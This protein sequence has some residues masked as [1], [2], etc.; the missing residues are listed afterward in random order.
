[1]FCLCLH[2]VCDWKIFVVL[3]SYFCL[4]MAT[5]RAKQ[6]NIDIA[7]FIASD[8]VQRYRRSPDNLI[9]Y[10]HRFYRQTRWPYSPSIHW[11]ITVTLQ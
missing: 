5:E 8:C 1:M 2:H 9:P 4:D 11:R 6:M 7:A 10:G 3:I